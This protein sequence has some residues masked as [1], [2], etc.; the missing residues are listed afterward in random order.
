MGNERNEG[1]QPEDPASR[2]AVPETRSRIRQLTGQGLES[3]ISLFQ[4]VILEAGQLEREN[5]ELQGRIKLL[6]QKNLGL[7]REL[8]DS[9][10][11]L[12]SVNTW[13]TKM[14][15]RRFDDLTQL[16]RRRE[17]YERVDEHFR[18]EQRDHVCLLVQFD[19]KD[20][21]RI[22]DE[23]SYAPMGDLVIQRVA[24]VLRSEVRSD[25]VRSD[26][27]LEHRHRSRLEYM[28]FIARIGGDEFIACIILDPRHI[29]ESTS[30]EQVALQI[31]E[32]AC[33]KFDQVPWAQEYKEWVP[34]KDKGI[35]WDQI[36][37]IHPTLNPGVLIIHA[38]KLP[39]LSPKDT[40]LFGKNVVIPE[41][42]ALVSESKAYE[43]ATGRRRIYYKTAEF[44]D[45]KLQELSHGFYDS[46]TET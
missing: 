20:F 41:T 16:P 11:A 25:I 12:I 2:V 5:E 3:L 40:R 27:S 35:T 13:A 10:R 24:K 44:Q 37:T 26:I 8:E 43:K 14:A 15:S 4:T 6:E 36:A 29:P 9:K 18:K 38:G 1:A 32:R 33:S 30:Y 45:L 46:P 39:R 23:I 7:E 21:K 31:V 28:D 19:V 22:N 17:F 42:K 34:D